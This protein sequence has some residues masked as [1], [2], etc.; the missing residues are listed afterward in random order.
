MYI[1][2]HFE[3]GIPTIELEDGLYCPGPGKNERDGNVCEFFLPDPE[4]FEVTKF[5]EEEV[6]SRLHETAYLN[7]KLTIHFE[8]RRKAE[9]E[10]VEYHEPEGIVGFVR[11]LNKKKEVLHEPVY[12][13]GNVRELLW[14]RYSSMSMNFMKMFWAFVTIFIMQKAVRI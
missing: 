13:S 8:D 6:K 9:T 2:D 1:T 11:D 3:R 5:A 12:F 4:I 7:P 14:R 10:V